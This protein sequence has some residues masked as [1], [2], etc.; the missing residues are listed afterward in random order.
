MY[1]PYAEVDTLPVNQTTLPLSPNRPSRNAGSSKADVLHAV[2]AT[3]SD[4][5]STFA[6][7]LTASAIVLATVLVAIGLLIQVFA[8]HVYHVTG[9]AVYTT[10]PLGSTL[11]I[12]HTS[13]VVVSMSAPL[14]I[15]LGAYWLAGKWLISSRDEGMD[16]PTP[17]Q[18]GVLME[19]LHGANLLALWNG[20]NYLVGRGSVPGGKALRRPPMLLYAVLM[21]L[22]FLAL[23]YGSAGVEMWLGATSDAVIYPVTTQ[24]QQ[25]GEPMPLLSRRVNQTLCDETKNFT[26]DKPYQCGYIR[27]CERGNPQALSAQFLTINGVSEDNVVAFTNDSTA[28]MVPPAANLSENLQ[29]SATT[30]GVKTSCTSVTAQCVDLNNTGPDAGL[31]L[32]CSS[33]NYNMTGTGCDRYADASPG[34]VKTTGGPLGPDGLVLPCSENP[35]TVN[36]RFGIKVLS[37]AY[38]LHNAND[39]FIGDTGFFVHGN[40]GGTN[41]LICNIQSLDVTYRY[42]N[43]TYTLVSSSAS[44]LAQGQRVSDG[45]QAGPHF[46]PDAVNGAGLFSGRYNDSFAQKLSQVSLAMTSYVMEPAEALDMQFID[47]KIGSRLP[48]APFLLLFII[49]TL[50][51]ISV[52]I[53]T[54][55]AI[56]QIREFPQ[57]ALARR[58]LIDPATAISTAYGPGDSK[59]KHSVLMDD[60][61]GH[62]T[63]ADRLTV[64]PSSRGERFPVIRKSTLV[65]RPVAGDSPLSLSSVFEK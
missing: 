56:L 52:I 10:A 60:L 7:L 41:I 38:N 42:F 34:F 1:D 65:Q 12:A 27:G 58:R 2:D 36:I 8:V 63:D 16:R 25:N 61:F 33:V 46:V 4:S 9:G 54:V 3:D 35:N 15:G 20:S 26:N 31:I 64:T 24:V 14:A 28:I 6:I 47:P 29:Y 13:S 22:A 48:L 51:C 49:S 11:T 39:E 59:F 21:L 53:V 18:L 5:G 43:G 30:L 32:D 50:Y 37:S 55:L 62:E 19:T 44:D 23:A 40:T 45:S 17:Y 57:A